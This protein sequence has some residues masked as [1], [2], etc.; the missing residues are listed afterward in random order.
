MIFTYKIYINDNFLGYEYAMSE[1]SAREKA[2]NIG[3][4][5]SKYTGAGMENIRAVKIN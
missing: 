4:S 5:A 3:G 1:Y 2:F